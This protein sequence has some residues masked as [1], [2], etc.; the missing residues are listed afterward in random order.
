[1]AELINRPRISLDEN[2]K[3]ELDI[4]HYVTHKI[5]DIQ[6]NF[7]RDLQQ[8]VFN[9]IA[10]LVADKADGIHSC[11]GVISYLTRP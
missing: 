11:P 7:G 5:Q 2:E 6:A 4:Q 3:V 1:M 9:R 10:S 8:D